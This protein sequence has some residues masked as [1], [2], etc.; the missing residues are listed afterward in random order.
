MT[1]PGAHLQLKALPGLP[2]VQPG[3]DLAALVLEG[4]EAM[5]EKPASGD[6]LILAQK[7]VSKSEGRMAALADVT[8]SPEALSLAK[9]VQKDPRLVEL[10]LSESVK[11]IRHRPGVL[12]VEH[13][14]GLIMA[15]A[16]IDKSNVGP[17]EEG[18]QV[19]L[20]PV[21]PDASAR[22]L[23]SELARRCG[24]NLAVIISDSVGR[25]WRTGT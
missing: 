17:A 24:C 11:V 8:P 3:D 14:L 6:V 10:I 15:N 21:D 19:L 23:R 22:K 20:L 13:R 9:E 16:G 1:N 4:C 2:M 18:E 7:I 5:G 12:V 25:A